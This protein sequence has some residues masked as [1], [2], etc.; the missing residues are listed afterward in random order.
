MG[1]GTPYATVRALYMRMK[2]LHRNVRGMQIPNSGR[3][4]AQ[5]L[6]NKS[7]LQFLWW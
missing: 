7:A 1:L 3:S 2:A 4:M 5:T 6:Y